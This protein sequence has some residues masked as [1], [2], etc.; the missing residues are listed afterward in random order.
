MGHLEAM[1]D[2]VTFSASKKILSKIKMPQCY[3]Q[4]DEHLPGHS[5]RCSLSAELFERKEM[6]IR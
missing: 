6:T 3:F 2:C 4:V 1:E 5:N